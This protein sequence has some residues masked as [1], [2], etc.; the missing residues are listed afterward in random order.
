MTVTEKAKPRFTWVDVVEKTLAVGA[1]L[2]FL[3][4]IAFPF[5]RFMPY[6]N[7]RGVSGDHPYEFLWAYKLR[8]EYLLSTHAPEEVWFGSYWFGQTTTRYD[9]LQSVLP[10]MLV[11]QVVTVAAAIASSVKRRKAWAFIPV[12]GCSITIALMAS[13]A[14]AL[15]THSTF[16]VDAYQTGYWL[17]FPSLALFIVGFLLT[18]KPKQR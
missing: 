6:S 11:V 10:L 3:G 18:V 16:H 7:I 4:S 5:C 12:A 13:T 2:V 15:S 14:S 8:T 1:C 17:A 9:S